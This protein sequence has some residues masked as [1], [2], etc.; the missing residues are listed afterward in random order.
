MCESSA[1]FSWP[2]WSQDLF[3]AQTHSW[4]L[5]AHQWTRWFLPKQSVCCWDICHADKLEANTG[6]IRHLMCYM[7]QERLL[8]P[9]PLPVQPFIFFLIFFYSLSLRTLTESEDPNQQTNVNVAQAVKT[10]LWWT[11]SVGQVRLLQ[12]PH[13]EQ[14]RHTSRRTSHR[15][16]ALASCP[17]RLHV[18]KTP[19]RTP[20]R[21]ALFAVIYLWRSARRRLS[22]GCVLSDS[23]VYHRLWE[24]FSNCCL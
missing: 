22:C 2:P 19:T 8:C 18:T 20:A 13:S 11:I 3:P 23:A 24:I 21:A 5:C 4:N 10:S 14:C 9:L 1:G 7:K 17:A 6:I 12:N 15:H 16:S